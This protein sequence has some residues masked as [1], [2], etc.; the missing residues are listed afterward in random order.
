MNPILTRLGV[1]REIQAFFNTDGDLVFNYGDQYEQ[2]I[3]TYHLVPSTSN[4]WVA[5]TP[6][7]SH[8]IITYSVMEAIAFISLKRA[9]FPQLEH[10]AFIAIGNRLHV[11]QGE[12]IKRNFAGRKITWC[13]AKTCWVIS[14]IL[15]YRQLLKISLSVSFML[16]RRCSFTGIRGWKFLTRRKSH[17]MLSRKLSASAHASVLQS[18]CNH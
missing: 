13:S 4:L 12:W 14:P 8:L 9:Q 3:E 17:Y 7:A 11:E 18:R 2:Y 6:N 1:S 5:G 15:N 10:L 16:P